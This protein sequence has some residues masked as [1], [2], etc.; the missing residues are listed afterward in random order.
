MLDRGLRKEVPITHF[1]RLFNRPDIHTMAFGD[2]L[3][4]AVLHASTTNKADS[5][6]GLQIASSRPSLA[7]TSM[8]GL[9][10]SS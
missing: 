1:V 6:C 3:T 4:V 7:S 10:G 9:L 2:T 8:S 5:K